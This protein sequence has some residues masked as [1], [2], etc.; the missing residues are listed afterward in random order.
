MVS[1][2]G[3]ALMATKFA[4]ANTAHAA[5]GQLRRS[6]PI[7]RMADGLDRCV[8]SQLL[9]EA[10]DADVDDVGARIEVVAPDLREE[11]L[12]A[13]HFALVLQQMVEDAKL[14]IRELNRRPVPLHH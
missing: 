2:P 6:N 10:P 13:D 1:H 12:A 3:Q 7:T 14:A 4:T 9:A 8:G 5:S 11:P